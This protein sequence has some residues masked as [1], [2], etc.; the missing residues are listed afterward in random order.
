MK[1]SVDEWGNLYVESLVQN[2]NT[3]CVF[4]AHMDHPGFEAISYNQ[5]N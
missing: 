2:D 5:N 4:V 3:P 1:V